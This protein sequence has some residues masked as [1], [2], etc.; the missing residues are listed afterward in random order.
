MYAPVFSSSSFNLIL[1]QRIKEWYR[2]RTNTR[3]RNTSNAV[4]SKEMK[5]IYASG[6]RVAKEYE[7]FVKEYSDLFLP[8]YEAECVNQGA[9]GR[10]RLPI[11][12]KVAKELWS[13]ATE[14]Q[15]EV[16]KARI[17]SAKEAGAADEPGPTTPADYQK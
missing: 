10:A 16:V 3:S 8:M 14:Q 2:W 7:V 1:L 4:T 17:K 13:T 15:K 6:S 11:W 12:H 9:V 5:D